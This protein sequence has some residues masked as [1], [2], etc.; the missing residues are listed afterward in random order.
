[1]TNNGALIQVDA[2]THAVEW[3]MSYPTFVEVQQQYYGYSMPTPI[4]SP[5]AMMSYG[6]ALYFKEYNSNMLYCVDPSVPEIKW[7]RRID[8]DG[9]IACFDGKSLVLTGPETE[10]I[11]AES[12]VLQ[13]D[14]KTFIRTGVI[15]PLIQ[16]DWM[17]LFSSKGVDSTRLSTG[18]V[19]P[20]FKGYDH[21]GDGGVLWKT[22]ARLVTV[23]SRAIT[24]YPLSHETV[25][26]N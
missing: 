19:G 11:D 2:G 23:S 9:G 4:I 15:H 21:D 3:A 14:N 13:W 25:H 7:K 22:P 18:E 20:R 12:R 6:P 16:G 5:G 17:Y 8:S 26:T 10:C 1:M 24:A